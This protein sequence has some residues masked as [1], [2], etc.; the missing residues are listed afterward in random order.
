MWLFNDLL[1]NSFPLISL[2]NRFFC[3]GTIV[4]LAWKPLSYPPPPLFPYQFSRL[5]LLPRTLSNILHFHGR[6]GTV[7]PPLSSTVDP[8]Q[9]KPSGK[10]R[11]KVNR[12]TSASR[13]LRAG[14][15]Q[16]C[17]V[18]LKFFLFEENCKVTKIWKIHHCAALFWG[19]LLNIVSLYVSMM[20]EFHPWQRLNIGWKTILIWVNNITT[21]NIN[22]IGNSC[23][24][25]C[26]SDVHWG[27]ELSIYAS[28]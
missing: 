14:H 28:I 13:T 7:F 27:R 10:S 20:R 6:Y 26:V 21:K 22:D 11:S 18:L 23:V 1:L 17:F 16:S 4:L 3:A 25:R 9:L 2:T 5:L 8:R 15:D 12:T 19:S 24:C